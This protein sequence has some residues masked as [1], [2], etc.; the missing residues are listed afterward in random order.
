MKQS[1]AEI[2]EWYKQADPWN[3]LCNPDDLTRKEKIIAKLSEYP[4]FQRA[5]DIGGGEGWIS[6]DLP[7]KSIEVYEVS[8]NARKRLPE[9][10]LGVTEATGNYDLVVATGVLYQ[11]YHFEQMLEIIKKHATK[12]ILIAGI[13]DW[14]VDT[15]QLGSLV[16]EEEF[17][18][19]EYTQVIKIYDVQTTA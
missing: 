10:I 12:V 11:H 6:K 2:E 9:G 15:T 8:E 16:Y 5:L 4:T 13:K 7:A 1:I 17:P 14:L 3:Y 19:R 18:Y